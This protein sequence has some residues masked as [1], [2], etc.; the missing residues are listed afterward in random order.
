M[1]K[2]KLWK[3]WKYQNTSKRKYPEAKRKRNILD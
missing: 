2:H 3:G 1:E